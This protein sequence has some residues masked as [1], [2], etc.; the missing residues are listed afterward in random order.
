M[1]DTAK[2]QPHEA[3]LIDDSIAH[4]LWALLRGRCPRCSMG[5]VFVGQRSMND[6]C[7][8][9]G[10]RFQREQ[11]Y[12][13]GAMYVSY[14]LSIVAIGLLLIALHVV[15]PTWDLNW[16]TGL[17]L[18]LYLPL[19]PA[20]FRYSRLLWI[21]FDRWASPGECSSPEAWEQWCRTQETQTARDSWH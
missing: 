7:P 14:P 18:V 15:L 1:A 8:V 9:C 13:L 5:Q 10:L 21:F 3:I 17:T 6:L 16:L 2:R 12:F 11:G 20:V 4:R 19:M